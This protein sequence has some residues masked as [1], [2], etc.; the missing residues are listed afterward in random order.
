MCVGDYFVNCDS[1]GKG[2]CIEE[3]WSQTTE[4]G[5][6]IIGFKYH[7]IYCKKCYPAELIKIQKKDKFA[8]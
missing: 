3:G 4:V 7:G 6:Q 5:K 8:R 2:L 1:C